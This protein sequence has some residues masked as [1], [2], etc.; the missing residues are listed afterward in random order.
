MM[1]LITEEQLNKKSGWVSS[2]KSSAAVE[3]LA[4]HNR[5]NHGVVPLEITG[6]LVTDVLVEVKCTE[7]LRKLK[8]IENEI[9]EMEEMLDRE[10]DYSACAVALWNL[11]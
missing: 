3:K 8:E 10:P 11:R 4:E 5:L 2:E 6:K 7:I 1:K 9:V